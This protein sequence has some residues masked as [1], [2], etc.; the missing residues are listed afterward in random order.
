LAELQAFASK[1][2]APPLQPWDFA[3]WSEKLQRE[4]YDL[5]D[6]Q[7]R[8][9]FKLESVVAGVFEHARRLYGLVFEERRDLP[10][11]HPDVQVFEVK[12]EA[13]GDLVG[14]FYA[15][16]FPRASKRGGAWMTTFR[17]Q[18]LLEGRVVRPHVSIV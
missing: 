11:Y 9:Y 1:Q 3:F 7:L 14:L 2:G 17:N 16:F 13:T 10:V 15:D 8:P 18:G 6:E 12:D 5:D 4:K